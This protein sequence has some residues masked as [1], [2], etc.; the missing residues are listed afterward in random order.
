MRIVVWP[1]CCSPH[2]VL[3]LIR[4]RARKV[5]RR[6]RKQFLPSRT[7]VPSNRGINARSRPIEGHD[8]R[9]GSRLEDASRRRRRN[10]REDREM[11]PNVFLPP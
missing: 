2:R 10:G 5:P 4:P 1:L 9:D 8:R 7:R 11:G 6:S 3:P